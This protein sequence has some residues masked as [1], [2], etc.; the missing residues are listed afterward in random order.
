[1][2]SKDLR[3]LDIHLFHAQNVLE[4]R[5]INYRLDTDEDVLLHNIKQFRKYIP[6]KLNRKSL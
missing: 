3:E 1:M 2:K 6:E 4:N 5:M